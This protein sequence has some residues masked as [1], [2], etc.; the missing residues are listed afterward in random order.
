MILATLPLER[1]LRF[2]GCFNFRDVGGYPAADGRRVRW[3][4][5]FRSDALDNLSPLDRTRISALDLATAIDLRTPSEV[6]ERS[7]LSQDSSV[8]D[9]GLTLPLNGMLPPREPLAGL[10]EAAFVASRY[11][12][13]LRQGRETICEVLA[14]LTD[15]S[16]YPVIIFCGDGR[17]RVGIVTAII[18]GLLDVPDEI[19]VTE[20]ML[21]RE[22]MIRRWDRLTQQYPGGMSEDAQ[23]Y[24]TSATAVMP[25]AIAG[26][27]AVLRAEYG[28]FEGYAEAIDM[29]G[30]IPHLRR[31]LLTAQ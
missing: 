30:A 31:A 1:C 13:M 11:H 16:L 7:S 6:A 15:P 17:D 20:Y 14:I 3:R 29:A 8:A 21:S 4:A 26:F 12:D 10:M 18:L 28:S 27:I 23:R 5:L 22:A 25:E 19:V 2:Q 24:G 9:A